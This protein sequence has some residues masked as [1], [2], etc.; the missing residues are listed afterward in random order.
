MLHKNLM[1]DIS[2]SVDS[3]DE[4]EIIVIEL[5]KAF[6]ADFLD[7]K[8]HSQVQKIQ[9]KLVLFLQAEFEFLCGQIQILPKK[10]INCVQQISGRNIKNKSNWGVSR[11]VKS[12]KNRL[13]LNVDQL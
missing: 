7:M 1:R 9:L 5:I 10:C 12:I 3:D 8:D 4:I 6:S 2:E 11:L 13:I